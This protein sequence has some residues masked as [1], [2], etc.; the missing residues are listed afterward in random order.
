MLPHKRHPM[1]QMRRHRALVLPFLSKAAL[2]AFGATAA[3]VAS[4]ASGGSIAGGW[5][6]P[7]YAQ[8]PGKEVAKRLFEEGVELEKKSDF[9]GAL[10]KYK[11]AEAIT[12]TPGL[13]FHKGYCLESL[14]KLTAAVDEYELAGKLAQA[15]GKADVHAAVAARL[16]PLRA[17]VPQLSIK[18]ST[19]GAKDLVVS[20]DTS[21]VG[22][23]LVGG[24]PFRIDPGEHDVRA[25]ATGYENFV[26]HVQVPEGQT[27]VVEVVLKPKAGSA[28][29]TPVAAAPLP[30]TAPTTGSAPEA[31]PDQP[32][33]DLTPHRSLA[34]PIAT[35]VGAVV[36]LGAGVTFF[37]LGGSAQT[38][39]EKACAA[40][41]DCDDDRTKVRTFDA[42]ALGTLIG[43]TALAVTSIVLWAA[44]GK[45]SSSAWVTARPSM[46]GAVGGNLVLEGRF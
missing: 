35:T 37:V 14:G 31:D 43:G 28:A 20:L 30:A 7:A 21:E 6:A 33:P 9:A 25:R 42:L 41:L 26:K 24:K 8:A 11:E 45:S 12:V 23:G 10:A 40:K 32:G 15:Q 17:R 1:G 27:T 34:A 22:A 29:A 5:I 2:G 13:R 46:S 36:L 38:D 19:P 18:V 16:D 39:G 3:L 44:G 4:P